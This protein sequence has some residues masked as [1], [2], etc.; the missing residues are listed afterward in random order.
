MNG[1]LL[2]YVFRM[3]IRY[4]GIDFWCFDQMDTKIDDPAS[5]LFG[6]AILYLQWGI[7]ICD[8]DDLNNHEFCNKKI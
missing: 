4:E 1:V 5:M 6:L 3:P 2:F 8:L 7:V